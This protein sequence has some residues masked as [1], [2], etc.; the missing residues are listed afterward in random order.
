MIFPT[1]L[2]GG[3]FEGHLSCIPHPA[4]PARWNFQGMGI[5]C[6]LGE[7]STKKGLEMLKSVGK[8]HHPSAMTP[9]KKNDIN[10]FRT[11]FMACHYRLVEKELSATILKQRLQCKVAPTQILSKRKT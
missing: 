1:S 10:M 6:S 11:L 9:R 3:V 4:P 2:F 5:L 7:S 8:K